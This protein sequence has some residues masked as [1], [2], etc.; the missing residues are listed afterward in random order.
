LCGDCSISVNGL[1]NPP[2]LIRQ[3][4]ERRLWFS[5]SARSVYH[6]RHHIPSCLNPAFAQAFKGQPERRDSSA[7]S[8]Q[9]ALSER[10]A[11]FARHR[12]RTAHHP[13]TTSVVPSFEQLKKR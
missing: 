5:R 12:A 6:V 13:V 3:D 7:F 1:L 9:L 8:T 11:I 10:A 2:S 4:L